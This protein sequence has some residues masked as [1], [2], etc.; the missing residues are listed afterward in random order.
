MFSHKLDSTARYRTL[1]RGSGNRWT[2]TYR[3]Q[4][5]IGT[6]KSQSRRL[7]SPGGRLAA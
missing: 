4:L 6:A 7:V 3:E 2:R 1:A 5:Q